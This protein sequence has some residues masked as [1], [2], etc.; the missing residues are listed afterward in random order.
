MVES[1]RFISQTAV[2]AR[3]PLVS[4]RYAAYLRASFWPLLSPH[5]LRYSLLSFQL[6]V[7]YGNDLLPL[8]LQKCGLFA[9]YRLVILR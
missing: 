9:M 4:M 5:N 1:E 6:G 8:R 7:Q 2:S 3:V